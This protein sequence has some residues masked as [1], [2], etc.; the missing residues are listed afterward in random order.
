MVN[1]AASE[2][3]HA[4]AERFAREGGVV[5]GVD[6]KEHTVGEHPIQADLT[7][8]PQVEAMYEQVVRRHGRLDVIYNNMGL[9][10]PGDRSP[11]IP[12]CRP[13]A[14]SRTPT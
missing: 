11:S 4:V 10:D 14:G 9:M 12:T 5:I 8:E 6:A 1:G 2:I 3:G 7:D 13:G